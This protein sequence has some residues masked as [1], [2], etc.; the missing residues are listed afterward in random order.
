MARLDF[1]ELN[2]SSRMTYETAEEVKMKCYH[3]FSGLVLGWVLCA[4]SGAAPL[5]PPEDGDAELSAQSQKSTTVAAETESVPRFERADFPPEIVPEELD[6]SFG[7]LVVPENR[8]DPESSGT[9][10]LAVAVLH[11][12]SEKPRPDPFVYTTGGPGVL[13]TVRAARYAHRVQYFTE[14]LQD[15]D[16][17]LFEQRGA[18]YS[19]PSLLGPEVDTVISDSV[20][21]T[22]NSTPPAEELVD[23]ARRMKARFLR[24]GVELTA[25][26]TVE[27]AADIE[28]LRRALKIERW[29]LAGISYSGKLMLE[30]IRRF[31]E[32][33]R[34]AVLDSPL[35]P[36]VSWDET[37]VEYYW[38]VMQQ[39]FA[40]CAADPAVAR[41]YPDLENRF[42]ALLREAQ[43]SP[44]EVATEHPVSE[45]PVTVTL[46]GEGLFRCAIRLIER[47]AFIPKFPRVI[48]AMCERHVPTIKQLLDLTIK[49]PS[50]AWGMVYSF[51]CNEELA[52]EDR[53]RFGSHP[54]LPA[55]LN[56]FSMTVVPPEIADVWPRRK[57]SAVENEPVESDVPVLILSGEYD[58]DTP[59]AWGRRVARTLPNAIHVVFPGQSHL[60]IFSHPC[61]VPMVRDFLSD[62]KRRPDPRCIQ[63][64]EPLRFELPERGAAGS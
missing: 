18:K 5:E 12:T 57:P 21:R 9:I 32:G 64:G 47:S 53:T 7:Y 4:P 48:H 6:A 16:V 55:P 31:P 49:P 24:E 52:F 28:D 40:R 8:Q 37:S 1:R 44:I 58:P 62:P 56:G 22:V 43:T 59:V 46:D 63:D 17:I 2:I 36:D 61:A 54:Q 26:N 38:G 27:S 30:V 11:S 10:R 41:R 25:Y 35:A 60:P 45:A 19:I 39:L 23:A 14:I 34:S 3:A 29:N 33:V 51:W 42:L 15:R 20:G 50:Y 13:S